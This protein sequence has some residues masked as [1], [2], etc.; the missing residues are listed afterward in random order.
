MFVR[1]KQVYKIL[2]KLID[3][4]TIYAGKLFQLLM[5]RIVKNCALGKLGTAGGL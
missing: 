5:E 4:S 3:E 2:N 1:P